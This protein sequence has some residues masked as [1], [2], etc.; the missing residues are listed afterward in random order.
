M[1]LLMADIKIDVG[2]CKGCCL[3]VSSC[4]IGNIE[5]SA[6]PNDKGSFYAEVVD[7][8]KCTGCALCCQ[9]CPDMAIEIRGKVKDKP[10]RAIVDHGGDKTGVKKRDVETVVR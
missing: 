4:P 3:C 10:S 1:V 2:R 8:E 9:M 6:E 5:M 7:T